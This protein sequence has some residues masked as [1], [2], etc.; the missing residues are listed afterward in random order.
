[1]LHAYFLLIFL[2]LFPKGGIKAGGTPLTWG[3]LY[4]AMT[5]PF[6]AL[7]RLLATPL[8][9]RGATLLVIGLLLPMQILL[10]YAFS[11]GGTPNTGYAVSMVVGLTALPWIFLLVYPPFLPLLNAESFSRCFRW[12]VLLAAAWGIFLFFLHPLTGHY[13]EIPY[14]TVNAADAGLLET[15]KHNARGFFQKL[16]S[17]YNNGNLYGVATLILMP[18]YNALEPSRWKRGVLFTATLLTLSR[19]VWVGLIIM[20]LAPLALLLLE[21]IR[22][23][24]V[25]HL[26]AATRRVFSV[27]AII[28]LVLF[29]LFF[30]T[31]S[32][33]EFLLDPTLGG[34]ASEIRVTSALSFL[35]P[36][37]LQGFDESLYGS[38]LRYYGLTGFIAFTSVMLSPLLVLACDTSALR[39]PLRMAAFSGLMLYALVAASDGAFVLI[40]IM[41]FY[42]FVYTV[43]LHGWPGTQRQAARHAAAP[44][45]TLAKPRLMLEPS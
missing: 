24:P 4:L 11:T 30:A 2:V 20:Q 13:I 12:C 1:M 6:L 42:W 39:S 27:I 25:L 32:G 22:T 29:V 9:V 36:A 14:L 40:P 43:F 21:Q 33:L 37:G 8:R 44:S 31:N 45:G 15:T 17:T 35:P 3:Y 16:I 41:A 34:R 23:F 38:A 18:L 5:A 28:G 26:G 7:I 19:T 10:A